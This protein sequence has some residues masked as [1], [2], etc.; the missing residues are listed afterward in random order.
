[1]FVGF[2]DVDDVLMHTDFSAMSICHLRMKEE[3]GSSVLMETPEFRDAA[4]VGSI[5]NSFSLLSADPPNDLF[6]DYWRKQKKK[7]GNKVLTFSQVV[8]DIWEPTIQQ[9]VELLDG[10][11]DRSVSLQQVDSL[12][13]RYRN[14]LT[15]LQKQLINLQKGIC[16]V[17]G[18]HTPRERWIRECVIRM[19]QYYF[20][21]THADA[22]KVFVAFRDR[23][24]LLGDFSLV[25]SLSQK[26]HDVYM[27][28]EGVIC[29][30]ANFYLLHVF[31]FTVVFHIGSRQKFRFHNR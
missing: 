29:L 3:S 18:K 31:C 24:G 10:L 19:E 20:L 27:H 17:N 25:E 13:E 4:P 14:K 22:A 11:K 30:C 1:M 12:L 2:Q 9:C 26:V 28:Y 15:D 8:S 5:V 16:K 7:Q 21:H 6:L 23:L